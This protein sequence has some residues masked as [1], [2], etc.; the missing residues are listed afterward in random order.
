[1]DKALYLEISK[2]GSKNI[3]EALKKGYYNEWNIERIK[4][5]FNYG[6][7]TIKDFKNYMNNN[8]CY[9]WFKEL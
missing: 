9:C 6:N 2:Q 3:N 4:G 1:M 7:G 5:A 8:K